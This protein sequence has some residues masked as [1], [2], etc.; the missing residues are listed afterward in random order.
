[1][2][3]V[4]YAFGVVG[5]DCDPDP[6][7]PL[8]IAASEAALDF[9]DEYGWALEPMGPISEAEF[10]YDNRTLAELLEVAVENRDHRGGAAEFARYFGPKD[11]CNLMEMLGFD[12]PEAKD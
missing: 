4:H 3:A 10:G 7:N 1:M 8:C 11:F 2:A 5:V 12:L 6:D 9:L